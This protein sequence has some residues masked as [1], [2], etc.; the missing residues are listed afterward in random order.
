[1]LLVCHAERAPGCSRDSPGL[2]P[3]GYQAK[4]ARQAKRRKRDFVLFLILHPVARVAVGRDSR[5]GTRPALRPPTRATNLVVP[6]ADRPFFYRR[7]GARAGPPPAWPCFGSATRPLAASRRSLGGIQPSLQ[8]ASDDRCA[9]WS[10]PGQREQRARRRSA[11]RRTSK[12]QAG[13][14]EVHRIRRLAQCRPPLRR[15]GP[16]EWLVA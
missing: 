16:S 15:S 7:S 6:R 1:M 5:R 10:I 8:P 2:L 11:P 3:R 12:R 14:R 13:N 9:E 4:P